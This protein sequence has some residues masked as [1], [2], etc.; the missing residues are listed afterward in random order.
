MIAGHANKQ[1]ERKM[2]AYIIGIRES[3]H[4]PEEMKLYG[5]KTLP[6]LAGYD[7][8]F[9]AVYGKFKALENIDG[10]GAVII[11]FATFEEAEAWYNSPAYREAMQ[12]RHRGAKYRIFLTDGT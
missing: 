4:D 6:T 2:P 5:E 8:K 7:P 12:H 10:D 9:L 3:V 11:E 1:M